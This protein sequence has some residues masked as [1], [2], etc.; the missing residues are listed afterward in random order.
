MIR[1]FKTYARRWILNIDPT[2]FDVIRKSKGAELLGCLMSGA[3]CVKEMQEGVGGSYVT[4][5]ERLR[6]FER[7]H[8][9]EMVP[10]YGTE[11]GNLAPNAKLFKLTQTG[12][13]TARELSEIGLI[14]QP[15]LSKQRQRWILLYLFMFGEIKGRTR[16]EKL[17][18]LQKKELRFVRGN[19]F[20]FKWLHY[21]PYSKE[22][23]LDLDDLQ[24]KNLISV[25]VR[26]VNLA[27]D[28]AH[29]YTY[30]L[31]SKGKD[32]ISSILKE[33][34][35]ETLEKLKNLKRF[36][37]MPLEKLLEYV[38]RKFEKRT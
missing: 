19:F 30:R 6:E 18:Y 5:Y 11:F 35:P 10:L 33:L 12:E 31:A 16:F 36:N 23:I 8:I 3:K 20:S 32:L 25:E 27:S 34:P 29:L 7:L 17:L 13:V 9:I 21:G 26:E 4:I 28:I 22:L 24:E 2:I 1:T 37:G 38:Y 15:P 14:R